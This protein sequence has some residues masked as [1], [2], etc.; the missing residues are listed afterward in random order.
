MRLLHSYVVSIK[1]IANVLLRF[2]LD[3]YKTRRKSPSKCTKINNNDLC[4]LLWLGI[5]SRVIENRNCNSKM[6]FSFYFFFSVHLRI[7]DARSY[8]WKATRLWNAKL[9]LNCFQAMRVYTCSYTHWHKQRRQ[10]TWN[11]L[12]HIAS[13]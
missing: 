4:R 5:L 13:S 6:N 7:T 9:A 12:V 10:K 3:Q 2:I 8:D 11:L 1:C